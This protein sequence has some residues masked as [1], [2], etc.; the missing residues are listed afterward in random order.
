LGEWI[1]GD[2][3]SICINAMARK[4]SGTA[5]LRSMLHLGKMER[6][7]YVSALMVKRTSAITNNLSAATKIEY[8]ISSTSH[9]FVNQCGH[10]PERCPENRGVTCEFDRCQ[11]RSEFAIR[12]LIF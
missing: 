7:D 4:A 5:S 3:L 8:L 6:S 1:L 10:A 9:F 12:I 2:F 11:L